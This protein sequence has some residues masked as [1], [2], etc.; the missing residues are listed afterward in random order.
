MAD[1]LIFDKDHYMDSWTSVELTNRIKDDPTIEEKYNRRYQKGDVIE[2]R[3]DGYWSGDKGRNFDKNCFCII[4]V[5]NDAMMG[6]DTPLY[7][8]LT[9]PEDNPKILKKRKYNIDISNLIFNGKIAI[10][11]Y[12]NL[13]ITAKE[14]V[15]KYV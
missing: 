4:N 13:N 1:L 3:P 14:E 11:T 15:K 12:S 9:L 7:D 10:S 6:F 2:V 8:T 5:S